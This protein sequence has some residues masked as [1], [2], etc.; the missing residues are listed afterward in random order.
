MNIVYTSGSWDLFHVGHLNIIQESAKLGDRLVVGVSSDELIE[1]YKG[2]PPV[3]PF[4]QRVK[5][6]AALSGVDEVVR[7]TQLMDIAIL[8]KYRI[9]VAT[10]GDDWK[11]RYLSGLEWMKENGKVVYIP[12]TSGVSTTSIKRTVI[13]SANRII[14]SEL[15]RENARIEEWKRAQERKG[16]RE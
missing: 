5:I 14:M 9:S 7:Q 16:R 11:D 15:H 12:Y 13:D 10:I 3:I 1:D 6:I 4:E 2:T 8:K